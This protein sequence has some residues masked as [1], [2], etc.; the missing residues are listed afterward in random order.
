MDVP[1]SFNSILVATVLPTT[2]DNIYNAQTSL[3][4]GTDPLLREVLQLAGNNLV[5]TTASEVIFTDQRAP[6][7]TIIDSIVIR[8][9]LQEGPSG[10]PGL[11]G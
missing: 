10:L 5:P 3:G 9:L 4:E 1:G 7:E 6:V 8:Y 2:S 11:S